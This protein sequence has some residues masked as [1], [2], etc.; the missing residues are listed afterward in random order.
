MKESHHPG[1]SKGLI[2]IL[3]TSVCRSNSL[4]IAFCCVVFV[5]LVVIHMWQVCFVL[6]LATTDFVG[7]RTQQSISII[8]GRGKLG[9]DKLGWDEV[10]SI[11]ELEAWAPV[12][13]FVFTRLSTC[14]HKYESHSWMVICESMIWM[15]RTCSIQLLPMNEQLILG[16]LLIYQ[17]IFCIFLHTLVYKLFLNYDRHN[18]RIFTSR[19]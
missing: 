13:N 14:G 8:N 9:R 18:F 11:I 1:E 7:L 6:F 17:I 5:S 16:M 4:W 2:L 3:S 15:C 19:L 10:S 12:Q